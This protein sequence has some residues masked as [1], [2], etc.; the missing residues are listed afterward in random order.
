MFIINTVSKTPPV[1]CCIV[2]AA[3]HPAASGACGPG[4]TPV[5][6]QCE[7]TVTTDMRVCGARRDADVSWSNLLLIRHSM[8]WCGLHFLPRF[9]ACVG[10]CTQPYIFKVIWAVVNPLLEERTRKKI[11]VCSMQRVLAW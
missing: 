5:T 2:R 7:V 8:P 10:C 11:M 9:A 6:N 1:S 3:V 4:P